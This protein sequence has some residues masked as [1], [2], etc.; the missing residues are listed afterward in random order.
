MECY[1]KCPCLLLFFFLGLN[2]IERKGI[3]H[4][5]ISLSDDLPYEY[6]FSFNLQRRRFAIDS[7]W[8]TWYDARRWCRKNGGGDLLTITSA[9]EA[10]L[11]LE[12]M[13]DDK[14]K[15]SQ[16]FSSMDLFCLLLFPVL[17]YGYV[18]YFNP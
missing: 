14:S 3:T 1:L 16:S 7:R 6:L 4:E 5:W 17:Y 10:N 15:V 12:K 18:R 2:C 9:L 11:L 8:L 13:L